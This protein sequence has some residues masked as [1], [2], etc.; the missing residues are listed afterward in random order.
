M[1]TLHRVKKGE[2]PMKGS[3]EKRMITVASD[4]GGY[5]LKSHIVSLLQGWGY[6]VEDLGTGGPEAVDYPDYAVALA[7]RLVT[8]SERIGILVC[9]TGIGMAITANR[10]AGVRAAVC[11]SAYMA[12][13]AR[14]H[15]DA[16]VLCLG[17]RVIGFGEAEDIL[18]TFLE[19]AFEG[20]RHA[21]RVAK[22]EQA[23]AKG[24]S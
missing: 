8:A 7:R 5:K 15:N 13:M 17:E 6:V 20:G 2:G 18:K 14:A 21:A 16:N 9:G 24:C 19:T 3:A 23:G 4:H 11:T 22:I 1:A 12:R 10:C